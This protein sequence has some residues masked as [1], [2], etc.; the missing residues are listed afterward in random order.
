MMT[1]GFTFLEV[2]VVMSLVAIVGTF[3]LFMSMETFRGSNFR[4]DRDMLVLALQRAR[5]EAVHNE[6]AGTC[7]DGKAHGVHIQSNAYILFQG[8][9]YSSSDQQNIS[10][11]ANTAVARTPASVDVV[12]SQLTGNSSAQTI[13]LSSQGKSSVISIST[14]GRISWTN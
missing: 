13:T 12:F 10:F 14:N 2:L 3:T 11:S 8:A 5:S 9:A 4:S 7:T 1:R 6:C